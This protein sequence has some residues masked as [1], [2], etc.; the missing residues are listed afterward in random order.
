M[1]VQGMISSAD[2]IV[3]ATTTAGWTNVPLVRA[4]FALSA[5]NDTPAVPVK[6]GIQAD[7]LPVFLAVLISA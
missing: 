4:L 7:T 5:V 3:A 6:T 2:H 1:V